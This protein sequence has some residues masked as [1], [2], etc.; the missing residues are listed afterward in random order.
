MKAYLLNKSGKPDVLKIH[1][2]PDPEPA[3]GEV[4][5]AVDFIGINYAEILSRK[6]MYE[7]APERPYIPGMEASGVVSAVGEG[8]NS[9]L[10]G[11]TVS[12]GTQYGCYAEKVV[13]PGE[14]LLPSIK[15]FSLEENA[16]FPVNYMTAWLSLVEM[17]RMRPGDTVLITAAAGGVGTAAI[18]IASHFGCRVIGLAGSD[19]KMELIK[20][21]G[22]DI[23]IN[24]SQSD[25]PQRVQEF[26]KGVD[27]ILE[28]VGGNVFKENLKLLNPF[29][30]M[31][32]AG[33]AG[34]NFKKWNPLTWLQTWQDMPKASVMYLAENS[35]G[36]L[37]THLGYLL[38]QPELLKRKYVQL[39]SF[40]EEH[41]IRPQIGEVFDFES[42]PK[43]HEY[44]ESRT[45]TG[46]VLVRVD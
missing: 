8:V 42:L 17:A 31:V 19:A 24:Y 36:F 43:A 44:I 1:Q 9:K 21:L 32:I 38:N 28:M 12:I 34:I 16:A 29:G 10:I 25:F 39:V 22:A 2:I 40:V 11:Q 18:Q 35:I 26:C 3:K 37:A 6:G 7:W 27:I 20:S 4:Q 13:I 46:K 15:G 41:K 45:S 30:R 23:A 14:R 5:V 33:F